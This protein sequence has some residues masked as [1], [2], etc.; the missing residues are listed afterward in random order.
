M[1]ERSPDRA[2]ARTISESS[3]SRPA[4]GGDARRPWEPPT[5]TELP[6]LTDLTLQSGIEGS[7]STSS[8]G[9]GVFP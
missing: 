6:R 2:L 1:S 3:G 9:S 4:P 7:G 5:L 8:G